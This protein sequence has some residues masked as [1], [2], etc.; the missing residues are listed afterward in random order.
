[1]EVRFCDTTLRDGE[2]TPGV[3]FTAEE[4]V[5]IA[6]ALDAAGVHQIEAG[7]PAMGPGEIEVLRRVVGAV[8]RAG[9]VAWCRAD[10]RDLDA[11]VA[12]GV[13]AVHVTI[14]ASDL[15]LRIKLGKTRAWARERITAC[16]RDA[17]DRG[18]LVS[19]GFEDASRADDAFVTDLAGELRGLGV[20]RFRWADTVG[21]ANPIALHTR[22]RAL[23][24]AVPGPWEIHAHDDFGL[25]TANTIA[26]VQAGF[27][28]VSTTVTGLGERAGNAPIEE[29]AMALRHLLEL[30]VELDTAA[31]RPLARLVAGAARRP[32]PAGKA[33]VGD[34]VFDHESGIHV[35]GVLRAPA[36]Y[37][38]FDPAEVGA[39]RRLVLGKHSG[40]AAVRHLMDRHGIDAPDEDLEPIVGLVRAHATTHKQPLSGDD[41]RALVRRVATGRT[42]PPAAP[43]G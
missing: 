12:S 25:A 7:I 41:L 43:L 1:M 6:V 22:L 17:T 35:H 13:S 14:P 26:A 20:T 28:W 32:L 3:A 23:V 37:E 5:A 40:R 38:P 19:V 11:A 31:F 30:P 34:E 10:Q 36:T 29:V 15:H 9:V 42:S 24:E 21:V 4:K 16:V 18:L 2:Q 27:T 33:V 8:E 39:S